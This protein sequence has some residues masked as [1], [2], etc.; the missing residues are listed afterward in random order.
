MNDDTRTE[1]Q[2]LVLRLADIDLREIDRLW[3]RS[4]PILGLANNL[5][6]PGI[7]HQ[8]HSRST[9]PVGTRRARRNVL[10]RSSSGERGTSLC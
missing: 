1:M 10:I 4:Q 6:K 8:A 5:E 7:T 2:T 3:P 9:T